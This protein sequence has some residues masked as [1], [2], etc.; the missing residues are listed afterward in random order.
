MIVA[1]IFQCV[2][3]FLG[4]ETGEARPNTVNGRHGY[5]MQLRHASQRHVKSLVYDHANIC[6]V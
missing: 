5:Q 4:A 3:I 1:V 2:C 6:D